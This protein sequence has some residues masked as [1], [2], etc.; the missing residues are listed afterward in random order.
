MKE[1]HHGLRLE[2][3]I[4]D[5]RY[6]LRTLARSRGFALITVLI[7]ALGIGANTAVFSLTSAVLLRPLPF[8]EPDR[9]VVLWQDLRAVGGPARLMPQSEDY[10]E[11]LRRSRSFDAMAA[12]EDVSFNLTGDGEPERLEASRT[13][14]NLF[15]VLGMQPLLGRTFAP[16]DEGP[17]ASPVVVIN[18]RLWLRR[19]GGDPS[20]IGRSI[21]LDGLSHTVIGVVPS[22]FQFPDDNAIW[23]PIAAEA[24]ARRDGSV[25]VVA[26]LAAGIA[27]SEAEAEITT[28]AKTLEQQRG[29]SERGIEITVA[30]LHEHLARDARPT[31]L[32]LLGAV[33]I[34]LLI[35]CANVANLLLARG[36]TRSREL[37]LRQALGAA[38]GRMV[39]QLLTESAVLAT[40]GVLVGTALATLSFGYLARLVPNE[41]PVGTSPD[42]DWRVLAFTIGL[43]LSTVALFGAGPALASARLG[44]ADNLKKSVGQGTTPRSGRLRDALVVAEI[45]LTVVLL[46]AGGLLFRSYAAVLSVDPGFAPLNLLVAQT[47]PSTTR[48]DDAANRRAFYR[49]VLDRVRAL[50]GVVGAGY[51]N[52]PPLLLQ[53]GV[54]ITLEGRPE[55]LPTELASYMPGTRAVSTDYL[56]TLGVPLVNGRRFDERDAPEAPGS[57]MINEAMAR[58]HWPDRDPI[59][60][61]LKLGDAESTA[62][63]FT[64]VGVVGDI[65]QMGLDSPP[66]PEVYFSL[67]QPPNDWPFLFPRHLVVRTA[68]DPLALAGAVRNAVW[69]VDPNQS[70]TWIRSMVEIFDAD[71]ANRNTQLTLVGGF[72]VLALLLASVGLYGVLSYAVSQRTPEI[73]V[74]MALGA[75]RANVVGSVVRR[76]LLLA[77][78][79]IGIGLAG[80]FGVTRF[81]ASFLFGVSPT[82]PATLF[83][84]SVAVL[85]VTGLATYVPA[86]RAA[87]VDPVSVLRSD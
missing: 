15:S 19:F 82:D 4:Q 43:T 44:L 62:P 86:R 5:V 45:T 42:L 77:V 17:T 1:R 11:W 21:V 12:L 8:P 61:R 36:A 41:F 80:A 74:R 35:T 3:F 38:H 66:E 25:Y 27:P 67:E 87:A 71:L 83:G 32:M 56:S 23:V 57:V 78:V 50:P 30:G 47:F 2:T 22:D 33:A 18:E 84:V 70:I 54:R 79:G 68:G 63:W 34:V 48:Y 76:A 9:L 69:E 64:V 16:D 40:A 13:T 51:V 60:A 58:R 46:A 20:V 31:L 55:P 85:I 14:A 52:Y 28:I 7:L 53:G 24:L 81:L 26:R 75:Q 6:A 29:E 65:R 59:G 72:A 73:G 39:R 37:A 49:G 10:A